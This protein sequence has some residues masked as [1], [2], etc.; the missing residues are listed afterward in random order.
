MLEEKGKVVPGDIA[1]VGC[2]DYSI[3]EFTKPALTTMHIRMGK[4]SAIADYRLISMLEHEEKNIMDVIVP[5][6]IVIRESV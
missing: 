1:I 3:V 2:R 5:G 6:S 4:M